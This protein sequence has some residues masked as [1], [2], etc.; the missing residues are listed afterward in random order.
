MPRD[1]FILLLL[2]EL[3]PR[4]SALL[5]YL[6]STLFHDFLHT[7]DPLTSPLK[8]IRENQSYS[9]SG[10]CLWTKDSVHGFFFVQ[11]TTNTK[12]QKPEIYQHVDTFSW[13]QIWS[14]SMI[15]PSWRN[16]SSQSPMEGGLV[17]ILSKEKWG[18]LEFMMEKVSTSAMSSRNHLHYFNVQSAR[19]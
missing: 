8:I 11:N 16:N 15:E 7:S 10:L 17:V 1:V 4:S 9:S 6:T 14:K 18:D 5:I 12:Q 3:V 19:V 2:V 13:M